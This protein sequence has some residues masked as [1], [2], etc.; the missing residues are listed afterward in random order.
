M[1]DVNQFKIIKLDATPSTSSFLHEMHAQKLLNAPT[2]VWTKCQTQ[3]RGQR[4]RI[5]ETA[6]NENITLSV[7]SP[8]DGIDVQDAFLLNAALSLFLLD[9]LRELGIPQLCVKWPN[10]ILSGTKKIAGI[11]IENFI[12]GSSLR[13]AIVGIGVNVNQTQ[14]A[15]LPRASSLK[16]LTGQ[17]FDIDDLVAQL[18]KKLNIFFFNP[19]RLSSV[20]LPLYESHLFRKDMPMQ[21]EFEG[22][23]F[24]GVLRGIST[25]GHCL[26]ERSGRCLAFDT[27][28]L[29]WHY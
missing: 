16:L 29:K 1:D 23:R 3:G 13:A 27:I 2:I 11:L 15:H 19:L 26:I 12:S 4:D 10:D 5:W 21:F 18:I 28:R 14:F 8:L 24:E 6:P 20:L 25:E 9:W 17:Q 7:Y 22:E